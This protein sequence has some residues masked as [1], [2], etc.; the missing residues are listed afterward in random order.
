MLKG[1]VLTGFMMKGLGVPNTFDDTGRLG[2]DIWPGQK[3]EQWSC[4]YCDPQDEGFT[5][6][7]HAMGGVLVLGCLTSVPEQIGQSFKTPE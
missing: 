5:T 6:D 4:S 7:V 1:L 3:H 2:I